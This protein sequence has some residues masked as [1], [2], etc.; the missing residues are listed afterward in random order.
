MKF[1]T[2]LL[3]T[4]ASL[5]AFASLASAKKP[6]VYYSGT[7]WICNPNHFMAH[8]LDGFGICNPL[9]EHSDEKI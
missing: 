7:T 1:T 5:A 8:M 4:L 6:P 2:A 9:P 3:A